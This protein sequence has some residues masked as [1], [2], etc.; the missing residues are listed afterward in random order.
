MHA[1]VYGVSISVQEHRL[2]PL[3]SDWTESWGFEADLWTDEDKKIRFG[4]VLSYTTIVDYFVP[5]PVYI[6]ILNI[7]DL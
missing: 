3:W 4:W 1:Y 7:Y 2:C 5:N 6:C